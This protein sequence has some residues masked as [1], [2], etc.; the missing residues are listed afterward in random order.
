MKGFYGVK[1]NFFKDLKRLYKGKLTKKELTR[2]SAQRA[3]GKA[4]GFSPKSLKKISD[5]EWYLY[6]KYK[7]KIKKRGLISPEMVFII[8]NSLI[9]ATLIGKALYS[10]EIFLI[11]FFGNIVFLYLIRREK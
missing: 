11:T 1:M 2:Q 5:F 10:G 6:K 8:F 3:L 4:W 7:R 9:V